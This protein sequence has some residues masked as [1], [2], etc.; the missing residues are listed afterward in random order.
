MRLDDIMNELDVLRVRGEPPRRVVRNV[1]CNSRAVNPGDVFVCIR[2][3]HHDG[4]QFIGEALRRGASAVVVDALYWPNP[5]HAERFRQKA[6]VIQVEDTRLA[7]AQLSSAFAGHPAKDLHLTGVT[8]T[9]GKTSTALFIDAL[10][11]AAGFKT[12]IVSTVFSRIGDTTLPQRLTTPEAGELQQILRR[13]RS[14]AVTRG[15]LEISS[16]ALSMQRV[17]GCRLQAAVFTNLT[18]DHLDYHGNWEDYYRS[19]SRIFSLV[20]EKGGVAVV[21]VDDA[22]GRRFAREL[23]CPVVTYALRRRADV[24]GAILGSHVDDM[25][26]GIATPDGVITARLTAPGVCNAYNALAAAATAWAQGMDLSDIAAGFTH[27]R[28]PPGRFQQIEAGQPFRV[29]VDFAHNPTGLA[30]ALLTLRMGL[31]GK[32]RLVF[33]S[34]GDDGDEL[35]R[36]LMGRVAARYA[37]EIVV[38]TDNPLGECPVR[39]AA[40]VSRGI[41]EAGFPPERYTVIPDRS[42]AIRFALDAAAPGDAVLIAGRGHEREQRFGEQVIALDDAT[43]T[44]ELLQAR[45]GL[46]LLRR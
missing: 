40:I 18:R 31:R 6:T 16:H 34:K 14:E 43:V 29:Y 32:L 27:M 42:E 10:Y 24:R 39:I 13:M 25:R 8:G 11:R 17:A 21:N 20:A 41:A 46:P 5:L 30:H 7:Y 9:N 37:H 4:H 19:K 38:T 35:K 33:G 1:T 28:L 2:G 26:L 22:V 45:Y 36:R 15:V 12:G 23:N 44:T 3:V